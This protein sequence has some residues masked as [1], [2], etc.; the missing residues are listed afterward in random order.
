MSSMIPDRN[1]MVYRYLGNTGLKVSVFGLGNWINNEDDAQPL[2]CTKAAILNGINFFDT[3]EHYG[4]GLAETTL[5]KALKELNV[6]REK[7]VVTTKLMAVG[8]DPNDMFLSRKHVVEGIRNSLKRLQ[9]EYVDIVYCHRYD[10]HTPMEEIVTSMNYCI[11]QGYALY[12]GTSEW[13]A[14][15]IMEANDICDR[16][17]LIRPVV[18]QCQY[19][20][21]ERN[22]VENEYRDLFK[23]YKLGTT[24]YSPL[25][26]GALTGK[27]INEVPSESRGTLKNEKARNKFLNNR[28]FKNKKS[29]D[30]KLI[31][32]KEMAESK[33]KC[34]LAQLALSWVIAN[35]DVSCCILG[36]SKAAQ[37]DENVKAL[38]IYKKLKKE[39]FIEIEKILGNTPKGEFDFLNWKELPS[40]RNIAMGID[41]IPFKK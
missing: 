24:V 20:M 31:K 6:P 7:I 15:Q 16:L 27:Y 1:K 12:W 41:Y 28:Y 3:A 23:R 25:F 17:R 22:K 35:P 10:M 38:E 13:T 37:I 11:E 30:E 14:C 2:E 39:D 32:L 29:F 21:F 8:N 26:C 9:L 4:D 40:R 5:G 34:T 18:E 19:N 36:A 33:F